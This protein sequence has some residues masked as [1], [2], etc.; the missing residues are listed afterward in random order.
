MSIAS[1]PMYD[2]PEVREALDSL[3][4][5]LRNELASSNDDVPEALMHDKPL[6]AIWSDKALFV[7]QCCGYDLVNRHAGVLRPVVTPR[8]TAPGCD[9]PNYCSQIVVA[10]DSK[11]D[12]IAAVQGGVCVINGFESHSGM[13]ALRALV[14]PFHQEDR[15][16]SRVCVSGTHA[17][18]LAAVARG[19][20]DICAI[21]CVTHALLARHRPAALAG[22]R[23]LC[24][25]A[26]APAIPF[27]TRIDRDEDITRR[28]QGAILTVLADPALSDV[29]EALFIGG[30]EIVPLS[31]YDSISEFER[32]AARRGYPLLC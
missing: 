5:V 19:E 14:A 32:E 16:F 28:L 20:A 1:F 9:G 18:S 3:W 10:E 4:A 12:E 22:T 29:C 8:Y 13:N 23:I 24:R 26:S 27:V 7:S 6:D 31:A 25:S 15:F 2:F 11:I 21:D 30:G 17:A